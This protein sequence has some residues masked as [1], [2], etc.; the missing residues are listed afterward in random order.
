MKF[1][2]SIQNS[3]N[4]SGDDENQGGW[5]HRKPVSTEVLPRAE[6]PTHH[7]NRTAASSDSPPLPDLLDSSSCTQKPSAGEDKPRPRSCV[8]NTAQGASFSLVTD[9]ASTVKKRWS[10]IQLG[11]KLFQAFDRLATEDTEEE[12]SDSLENKPRGRRRQTSS[13]SNNST[14]DDYIE[15]MIRDESVSP[16]PLVVDKAAKM[17][18]TSSGGTEPEEKA[19]S[20]TGRGRFRR[21]QMKW[22]MLSGKEAS[23]NEKVSPGGPTSPGQA[24]DG[25][26]GS[27]NTSVTNSG[28]SKIP[29]PVT[30][31]VRA[32]GIPVLSPQQ[33]TRPKKTVVAPPTPTSSSQLRR[34]SNIS[35]KFK[36]SPSGAKESSDGK[37]GGI[38]PQT[39][40]AANVNIPPVVKRQPSA[41]TRCSRVD[42]LHSEEQ[43][44][45]PKGHAVRPSSL[46]YRPTNT[47]HGNKS[48]QAANKVEVLRRAASSSLNRQRHG[49]SQDGPRYVQTLCHR[50][51]SDNGHLSF[52][53]GERL[54]LVLEVDEK[55]LLCC[56]G[57][58]K[59]L[60]P[61]T[62]VNAGLVPRQAV[63][64]LQDNISRF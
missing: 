2:R 37:D 4:Q 43:G 57:D 16:A 32:S 18:E 50:L 42:Q 30:S 5:H 15:N 64:A 24:S 45:G 34:P 26:G 8:D 29:R 61:R 25:S 19:A 27:T 33:S 53:E 48:G 60:V 56:R 46:P 14:S 36:I 7:P 9:I 10:G 40:K 3:L 47:M 13:S 12:Y 59:G 11:S 23:T 39:G 49:G 35:A 58:Q 31:P 38:R 41:A 17:N 51:P 1:V 28:R 21:L 52:N 63:I 22:E 6:E 44:H 55:W 20:V 62:A 54:R